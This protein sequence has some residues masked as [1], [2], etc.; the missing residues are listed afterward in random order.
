MSIGAHVR[1]GGKLVPALDRGAEI[2]AEVIQVFTQSP[3]AWKPTQ[4]SD[5]VLYDY[6]VAQERHPQVTET[7]C[8][9]TYLIN[10]ASDQPE[11]LERSRACLAANLAVATGMGAS[12]LVLHVGSHKGRGFAECVPQVVDALLGVLAAQPGEAAP[13]LLENAAGTGD[14]V[15]R[16]FDELATL[17]TAAGRDGR[18][19][20]GVCLDTQHLWASGISYASVEEADDIVAQFDAVIGLARLRCLHLNDSKV[21]LGANRDRH[22]NIGEGTIGAEA[23]GNLISHP[24]LVDLPAMLEVPGDGDGARAIDI[25]AARHALQLGLAARRP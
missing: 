12:G 15:G 5:E 23:L 14:T 3:R 18:Q 24:A 8:H 21:E 17:L 1:A 16:S 11:V 2:G 22:E 7:F 6:R 10:L 25:A 19:A 13:I 4:Y 9:A 20:L